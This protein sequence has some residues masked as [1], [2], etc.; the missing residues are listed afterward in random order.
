MHFFVCMLPVGNE[1]HD[2]LCYIGEGVSSQVHEDKDEVKMEH[3]D[4]NIVLSTTTFPLTGMYFS[5][6][7][8][9]V[10]TQIV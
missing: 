4:E 3:L 10:A 5:D 1:L 9:I 8:T 6:N 2:S 7:V